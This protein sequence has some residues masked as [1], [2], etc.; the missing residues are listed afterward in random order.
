MYAYFSLDRLE[1]QQ[2]QVAREV[3][4]KFFMLCYTYLKI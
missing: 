1:L 4:Y 3:T 2:Q